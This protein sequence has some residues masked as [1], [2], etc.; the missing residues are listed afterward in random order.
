MPTNSRTVFSVSR[1][2]IHHRYEQSDAHALAIATSNVQ[3]PKRA[4]KA[5]PNMPACIANSF[6][7]TAGPTTRNTSRGSSGTI[8]MLAA[9]NASASEHD[10]STT[11]RAAITATR[12]SGLPPDARTP[13]AA[14][15]HADCGRGGT[16]HQIGCGLKEVVPGRLGERHPT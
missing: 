8:V 11:A 14:P 10:A 3:G 2:I 7:S 6:T 4:A 12:G 13:T 9:T 1:L 16:Q 5:R 15:P